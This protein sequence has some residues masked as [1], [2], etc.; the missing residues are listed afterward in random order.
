MLVLRCSEVLLHSDPTVTWGHVGLCVQ[1]LQPKSARS[2]HVHLPRGS[3]FAA[4][5]IFTGLAP[6]FYSPERQ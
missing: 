2:H 4:L 6:C 1:A 5:L 3:L